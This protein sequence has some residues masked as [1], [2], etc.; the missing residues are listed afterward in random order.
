V[1][2]I[3][4]RPIFSLEGIY[5]LRTVFEAVAC[6]YRHTDPIQEVVLAL[7]RGGHFSHQRPALQTGKYKPPRDQREERNQRN[8]YRHHIRTAVSARPYCHL[9]LQPKASDI[10]LCRPAWGRQRSEHD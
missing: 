4:F 5:T 3:G 7:L 8:G 1:A 6:N 2:Q 9:R 10:V